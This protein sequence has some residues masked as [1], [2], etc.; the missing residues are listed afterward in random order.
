[1]RADYQTLSRRSQEEK[2]KAGDFAIA[3]FARALLSTTDVLT[4]ALKH[5]PQPVE[6]GTPLHDFYSGVELTRK[7]MISTF[8]HHGVVPMSEL[9]GSQFDPNLH[10][11][12]FQVPA[13]VAPR[14]T[15]G[16]ERA[17]G[18]I[19]EIAKDGWMIKTRV[20]RPAQV[21]VVQLE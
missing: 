5:V 2:A 11:A 8:E 10:E 3:S 20:L 17:S 1:M 18:E 13:A 16:S 14:N 21:G 19:F 7:A 12:T 15:D 6:K 9:L 4:T